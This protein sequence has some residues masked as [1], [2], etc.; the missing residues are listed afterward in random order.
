MNMTEPSNA[1]VEQSQTQRP[2]RILSLE[3][4]GIMGAFSASVLA[5]LE[6]STGCRCIDHFDLIT[7][8]STG[9]IIAI[10]LGLGL[11]AED[12]LGFYREQGPIIFK[13]AGITYQFLQKVRH[14]FQPKHS[15]ETLR[16]S[17]YSVF[18]DRKFGESK[19][20]LLI[21]TYDAIGGR[22]FLMKTAHHERF[23]FD[24]NALAVDVALATASA[25]TYFSAAPFPAHQSASYVD[26]GV[27]ANCPALAGLVEAVHFLNV[28]PDQIDILNIGTTATP[29]SISQNTQAGVF[30]WAKSLIN[31]FMNS[32]AE[33]SRTTSYLLTK[34]GFLNINHVAIPGQF[35]LDNSSKVNELIN[36]GRGE[37][38]KKANLE[39]VQRRFL[40]GNKVTPFVPLHLAKT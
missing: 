35:S 10:G 13:N 4:G 5:A 17:L 21:P 19:C 27:W 33:A 12:I 38:V 1:F 22:I 24:I 36:L 37:A 34:G 32:Q 29:F 11:S 39:E 14:I 30:G 23:R 8:T 40:N 9:G 7:G 26:G 25:P 28:P 6:E 18:G 15:Q 31:L 2:F 3:G 16:K 20:R